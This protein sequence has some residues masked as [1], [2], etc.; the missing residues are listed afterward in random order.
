MYGSTGVIL[1]AIHFFSN[2]FSSKGDF[3]KA[4]SIGD[5]SLMIAKEEMTR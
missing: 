3:E 2:M 1:I 4:S 5:E